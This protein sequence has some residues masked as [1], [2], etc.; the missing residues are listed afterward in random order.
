MYDAQS[1]QH[2]SIFPEHGLTWRLKMSGMSQSAACGAQWQLG[3]DFGS[4][5][6]RNLL[7]R[8][9]LRQRRRLGDSARGI[10]VVGWQVIWRFC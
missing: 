1:W 2:A 6:H 8:L 7:N 3:G 5:N 10:G 9:P 4:A